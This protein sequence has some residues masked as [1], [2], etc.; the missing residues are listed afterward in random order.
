M[1]AHAPAATLEPETLP[2][3]E[4]W[5]ADPEVLGVLLV[6]SKS[7][8]F[9]DARSD[10]D[11]EVLLVEG[12]FARLAPAACHTFLVTG[13]GPARR[14]VYDAQFT[15]LADLVRKAASAFDLDHWPYERARVLFER[16]NSV[17]EA[18][19]AAG[20][21][22]GAFRSLR[23]Q[24]ATID[25]WTS[26]HRAVKTFARG[27]DGAG[28]MLV[29]RGLRALTRVV[30]ALESRWTPLDHWLERELLTLDDPGGAVP[31]L[32]QS[33]ATFRPEPL[34][35][36]LDRL[37]DRLADEG[38]ARPAGRREL[39]LELIHASRSAERAI[40]GL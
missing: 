34:L 30:F 11:L 8:G 9:Q 22:D 10:D 24:H 21:M 20:R 27:F 5:R 32:V 39:F 38:V 15:A 12:A 35:A 40:H 16:E 23:L 17:G 31:D 7:R 26:G 3:L 19:R 4:R 13:E 33:L 37:E 25:A 36:A 6:G 18:V 28:R 2:L 29:A 14:V 1:E